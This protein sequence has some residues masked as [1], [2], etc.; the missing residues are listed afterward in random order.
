MKERQELPTVENIRKLY[1]DLWG[2]K[3]QNNEDLQIEIE[4]I[5]QFD[6]N[7]VIKLI[8]MQE[9]RDRINRVKSKSAAG[10]DGIKNVTSNEQ[11]QLNY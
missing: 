11:A 6:I 5:P 10:L 2:D 3:G 1:M 7:E 8:A 9:I 4:R